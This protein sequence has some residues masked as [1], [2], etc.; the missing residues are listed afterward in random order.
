MSNEYKN[1]GVDI[2]AGYDVVNRIKPLAE[3]TKR[4]GSMGSIGDFGGLFDLSVLQYK[5]P[6]LVSGTDGVGTKL[7][8]AIEMDKHDTIGIDLVA[9]SVNDVVAQGAEPLFFL[10]YIAVSK[11][12]PVQIATVIKGIADAC[13]MSHCAL[14][15]G[16][17]AEMPDMY[18]PK[19][20]D[21]AGF[22]VGIAEKQKLIK[23]SSVKAG[24]VLIGL[25]SSGV[26]SNGFSLVR[27]IL[28]K[29]NAINLNQHFN[30]L[31]MSI[32]EALLTPTKIYVSVVLSLL[33]K[34]SING[35]AHI[36]GGGFI[37]NI[38]RAIP[39]ELGILIHKKQVPV[40]P[41]FSLLQKLGNIAET[42]MYQVF[43]MGIGMVLI[44]PEN[45][46]DEIMKEISTQNPVVI[47]M[48]TNKP[49]S[50][51]FE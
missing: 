28:F 49:Q 44:V 9:M 1:S 43:N 14:I 11:N 33:K 48:V 25:P 30:E 40:L 23:K 7:L 29:D 41:I 12:N 46:V 26:H 10:D 45:K 34:F 24:D 32:G 27:K 37:E 19:H 31:G 36:T 38:P 17:T 2:F 35:I 16:E 39:D 51:L 8:I 21:L 15:G 22:A 13:K 50:F 47:G 3:A 42:E 20:Y 18:Q 4:L 6:V 5:E